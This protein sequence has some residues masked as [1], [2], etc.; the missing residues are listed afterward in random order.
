[1]P[2]YRK[3]I[4]SAFNRKGLYAN[5][6]AVRF[7]NQAITRSRP[8]HSAPS[9]RN[10]VPAA[11]SSGFGAIHPVLSSKFTPN[12]EPAMK[13]ISIARTNWIF[14]IAMSS[15]FKGSGPGGGDRNKIFDDIGP[16]R[17]GGPEL[18]LKRQPVSRRG[19]R[20]F[21]LGR[22]GAAAPPG[23]MDNGAGDGIGRH[24]A[25]RDLRRI[26]PVILAQAAWNGRFALSGVFE[27]GGAVFGCASRGERD[28]TPHG[29]PLCRGGKRLSSMPGGYF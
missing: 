1:M 26:L 20:D 16:K 9:V 22:H 4:P 29:F 8:H 2:L 23:D 21:D 13:Q 19:R 14:F 25:L 6:S 17:T 12:S 15:L 10:L 7:K 3:Q 24:P 5:G 18:S 28:G 11:S 27:L